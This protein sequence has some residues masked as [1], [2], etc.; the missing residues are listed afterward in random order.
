[1]LCFSKMARHH[2]AR[3]QP[4]SGWQMPFGIMAKGIT[5]PALQL[6]G[7]WPPGTSAPVRLEWV[8]KSPD[9]SPIEKVWA[10]MV[11]RINNMHQPPRTKA[12]LKAAVE[13]AWQAC[14]TTERR[15][16][17]ID[18]VPHILQRCVAVRGDN[19]F[20]ES[21]SQVYR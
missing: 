4:S 20:S 21:G 8:A 10:Q 2:I 15:R 9:F 19:C 5:N 16:K 17:L 12:E 6:H 1:M 7:P 11:K 13:A 14:T 18:A 3:P